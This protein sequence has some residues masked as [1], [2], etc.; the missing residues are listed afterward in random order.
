MNHVKKRYG[1]SQQEWK[2]KWQLKASDEMLDKFKSGQEGKT[3]NLMNQYQY[4]LEQPVA[5]SK[6]T[7]VFWTFAAKT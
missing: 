2:N 7:T 1:M 5:I 3:S 4:R 6:L